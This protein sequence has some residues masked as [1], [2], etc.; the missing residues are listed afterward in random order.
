MS[1]ANSLRTRFSAANSGHKVPVSEWFD[2]IA[3]DSTKTSTVYDRLLTAI[4]EPEIVD[5]STDVRLSRIFSNRKIRRYKAFDQF[6]GIEETIEQIVSFIRS[7]ANGQEQSRQICYLLGPVGSSKTSIA[8]RLKDLVETQPIWVIGDKAGNLSPCLDHPLSI[9]HLVPG[10]LDVNA[11]SVGVSVSRV[12]RSKPSP[13]LVQMMQDIGVYPS[14][15]KQLAVSRIEPGDE[16]NQDVS[17]IVGKTDLRQLERYQQNHA[18]SYS[19]SGGLNRGNQGIVEFVEIFKAPIKSLHPLLV[20][21]QENIFNGTESIG[22]MPFEGIILAHSNE[23]E[24]TTFKNDK[25]HEAFIDR[26][27]TIYVP[28]C[29]RYDEEARIY[30]K[31][32][33]NTALEKAP[34]APGTLEMLAKWMVMTRMKEPENSTIFAKLRV[35]NGENVKDTMPNAKPLEEYREAAG[36]DEGMS[37]M[38]TRFAFKALSQVFDLRPESFQANPVDLM[39]VLGLLVK[40]ESLPEDVSNRYMNYIKNWLQ[41]KYFEFLEKELRTAYLASFDSYGQNMFERYVMFAEAWLED[42]QCKDPET[43]VSLDRSK[44]NEKCEEIEKSAG[45]VAAKEF[46]TDIVHYV[47]KHRAKHG[48]DA[49]RWNAYEKIRNVI[50]KRM[51]S[52][53]QN[54]LPVITFGP[55]SNKR[56]L[57]K[58][59]NEEQIRLLVGWYSNNNRAS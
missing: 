14:A 56:M 15:V 38:S 21:T 46:R 44:L 29:L 50:E 54:I 10:G 12:K 57:D 41:P 24:W 36:N 9:L 19:Y 55:K 48:G 35:Y 53:T 11:G 42:S 31:M 27:V 51:F 13:W 28:Y 17:S 30:Q 33:A 58:G 59:Y 47:L 45:I 34:C 26:I 5:T 43:H 18:Y 1:I 6:Y 7:A 32:M 8:E 2:D 23:S 37:G 20:A 16:N 39:Y 40:K 22:S 52:A 4:G 25:R 3:T 49:P